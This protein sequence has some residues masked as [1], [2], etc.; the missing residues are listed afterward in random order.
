MISVNFISTD[1]KIHYSIPC[2]ST[3]IFAEIEEKLYK[4]YPEYRDNNNGF[5][6]KGNNIMRFKTLKENKIENGV[7]IKLYKV[8]DF[9]NENDNLKKQII[10]LKN[11]INQMEL[12]N[13]KNENKIKE[14]INN[15]EEYL[16]EINKYKKQ[17]ED[18]ERNGKETI[19]SLERQINELKLA[20]LN[21]EKE[22]KDKTN[23]INEE[24][25]NYKK[26]RRRIFKN[27][28]RK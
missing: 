7:P 13:Q 17:I 14:L 3:D 16:K 9:Q 23:S 24:I 28:K 18:N 26:K 5:L 15:E 22:L 6:Y 20:K 25:N 11:Q 12:E 27:N 8:I 19:N 2:L 1:D 10:E 4:K 21:Y